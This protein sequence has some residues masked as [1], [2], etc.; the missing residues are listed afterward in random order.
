MFCMTP[1]TISPP[2]GEDI[3]SGGFVTFEGKVRDHNEGRRVE[4][5]EYESY[6]PLA[7]SEGAKI[8]EEAMESFGLQWAQAIHRT[9]VLQIGDTALWV[10]VAAPHREEAFAACSYIVDEIKR[11][12][13]IW[14]KEHYVEGD[15]QWIACHENPSPADFPAL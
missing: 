5:L 7:E 9:G 13:P 11:R 10:S 6:V 15:S 8:M 4:K 12:V 1:E 14:K 2:S 3:R